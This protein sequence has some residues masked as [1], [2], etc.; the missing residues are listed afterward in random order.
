MKTKLL[1]MSAVAGACLSSL[2]LEKEALSALLQPAMLPGGYGLSTY[3]T[4]FNEVEAADAA[5]DAA[6]RNLGTRAEYDAYRAR[7]RER[8]VEAIG[9]F[10]EKKDLNARTVATIRRKGFVIEKVIFESMPGA[11]VT[12]LLFLPDDPAFKPPYRAFIVTCGHSDNGKG[13]K[14]YQRACVQ[15]ALCGF[16][17][18]IY[19]PIGQGERLQVPDTAS[20]FGH[21]RQGV[22]AAMLGRSMAAFRIW[23][24]MRTMDYLDSRPDIVHGSYGIMGNSGGGTM[25]SLIMAVEPRVSAAAPSCYLSSIREV[26]AHAG[27][28]DAEQNIF[29]QL[30]FGLNHA[31]F[32]LMGGNAVRMHCCHGDFFPFE[33]ARETYRTVEACAKRLDL[34]ARYG[35]TDVPG[36]HGW[37]ESARTSSVQWMRRW[38]AGDETVPPIDVTACR[39]L[40]LGFDLGKVAF[41]LRSPEE[42]PKENYNVTPNGKVSELPGFK[43]VYDYLRDDLDIALKARRTRSADETAALVRRLA[44]I[45]PS[46]CAAEAVE[47]SRKMTNG[48]KVVRRA[49]HFA[50]GL[51]VPTVTFE[52]AEAKGG[53]VLAVCDGARTN[54]ADAVKARLDEGRAVMVAD[55]IGC[56]EIGKAKHAFYNAKNADEEAAVMLYALG[57]SLVGVRTEEI[58][59]LADFLKT[60]FGAAP[61]IFARGRLAIPAAHARAAD[62]SRIAAVEVEDAP[63][64][65]V[66]AVRT[67][68]IQPYANLVNGALREYDWTDLLD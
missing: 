49:F 18:L 20:V 38:L 47:L 14:D 29:G 9:G 16:A 46:G 15:G 17:S 27:P 57:R 11:F 52:P 42:D 3:A 32:V 66:E 21:N 56:G 22:L 37:K 8:Y 25:T 63:L 41:G 33:G 5:A 23:D 19:D 51:A 59:A 2:A 44:G 28:Q 1:V 36:P 7:M 67:A 64:A 60:R 43:S 30:A 6:W 48:V 55:L 50:D 39:R 40:D 65:W 24:G 58:L 54:L 53:P 4:V 35:L 68:A 26:Y 10:P 34:S 13:A 62:R 61:R 12:G 45:R 31:G